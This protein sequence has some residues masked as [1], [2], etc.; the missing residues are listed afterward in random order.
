M[1]LLWEATESLD[2]ARALG[3][4]F[5]VDIYRRSQIG[6][7]WSSADALLADPDL[8]HARVTAMRELLASAGNVDSESVGI[9]TAASLT[10]L[11]LMARLLSPVF[12][13]ALLTGTLPVIEL[14]S[15][16]IGPPGSGPIPVA[17]R[18]A[19]GVAC[20]E[21]GQ[22]AAAMVQHCLEPVIRPVVE[23]IGELFR[24]SN[25]ILW[26]NATSA[27]G[28]AARRVM[29]VRPDLAVE[30]AAAVAALL[31]TGPLAGAGVWTQPKSSQ[32]PSFLVR[33]SCCLLYRLP[34]A[35]PCGD[36]IL[37]HSGCRGGQ[38]PRPTGSPGE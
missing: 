29:Q 17:A 1:Q 37:L 21:P 36:C 28:G 14:D 20:A 3:P 10:S 4:F 31:R 8:M 34:G 22:L 32:S 6:H 2:A 16:L 5:A 30:T 24:L 33:R 25:Q 38:R 27:L 9:R 15:W 18:A 11:G 23:R 13:G 12:G 7:S 26:G 19:G 35:T